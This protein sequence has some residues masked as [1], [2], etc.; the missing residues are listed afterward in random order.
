MV[1]TLT[2]GFIHLFL[3]SLDVGRQLP[4]PFSKEKAMQCPNCKSDRIEK[5]NYG[6]RTGTVVG[7][8]AGAAG[9]AKTGAAL[10][11]VAAGPVGAVA[12]SIAGSIIG[13]LTGGTTGG[14]IGAKAGEVVDEHVLDNY[15]CLNCGHDFSA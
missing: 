12:G 6:K 10:G 7:A 8:V 5:K 13:A 15:H 4:P 3:C 11:L 9:G 14:M 2:V 1:N